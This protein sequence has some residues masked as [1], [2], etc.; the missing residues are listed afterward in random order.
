LLISKPQNAHLMLGAVEF[1][2]AADSL[3]VPGRIGSKAATMKSI[4]T[5]R[6]RADNGSTNY[7][8]ALALAATQNAG[9]QARIFLT[10]G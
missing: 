10:D 7:N 1:G 5:R 3:F 4:L 8:D 2:S 9:A 6:V